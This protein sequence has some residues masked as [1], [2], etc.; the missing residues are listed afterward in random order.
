MIF[1]YVISSG[2]TLY[3]NE[4]NIFPDAVIVTFSNFILKSI[5]D[6]AA[7][8]LSKGEKKSDPFYSF[9]HLDLEKGLCP[10]AVPLN[11]QDRVIKLIN[12]DTLVSCD[13]ER[14]EIR[15]LEKL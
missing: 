9:Y 12:I 8:C 6:R 11:N 5:V 14:H 1:T 7:M 2:C 4:K 13:A 15:R 10:T 3:Y